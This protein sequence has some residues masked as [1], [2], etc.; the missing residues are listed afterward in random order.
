[1]IWLAPNVFSRVA[2][3]GT[4]S[5]F[6][7]SEPRCSVTASASTANGTNPSAVG[8]LDAGASWLP[9]MVAPRPTDTV[10]GAASGAILSGIVLTGWAL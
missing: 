2:A 6:T 1:M 4:V 5:P 10:V 7:A 9:L 8:G 3:S